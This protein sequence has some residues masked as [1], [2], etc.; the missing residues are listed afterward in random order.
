MSP[1]IAIYKSFIR[2]HLENGDIIY[3]QAYTFPV[4]R[5][6]IPFSTAPHQ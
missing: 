4:F 2:P 1:L 5:N 3:D 6:W